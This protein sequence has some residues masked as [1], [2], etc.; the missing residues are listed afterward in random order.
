MFKSV[1]FRNF[2]SL[3]DYTVHLRAVNVLVGPNNAG[4]STILDAFRAM[5]AAH[6][7]ASR[8]N[9]TMISV[10]GTTIVGYEIPM[11]NFPIS[12]ANIHSDYQTDH[13]TCRLLD[14][15]ISDQKADLL[16]Q[17]ISNRVRFFRRGAQRIRPPSSKKPLS[18]SKSIGMTPVGETRSV[19]ARKHLQV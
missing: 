13:E 3:K 8:R 4:K 11:S 18:D 14:R 12:L 17:Y 9:Q 5:A 7:Y 2:K 16:G 1:K 15:T 6:R 10:N 19:R